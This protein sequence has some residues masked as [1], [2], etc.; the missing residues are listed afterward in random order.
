MDA[1]TSR[2]TSTVAQGRDIVDLSKSSGNR[3]EKKKQFIV[4]FDRL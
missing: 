4:L 3:L 2:L 1:D